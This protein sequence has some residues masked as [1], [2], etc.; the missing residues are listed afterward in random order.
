[1][2]RGTGWTSLMWAGLIIMVAALGAGAFY[3]F[4]VPGLSSARTEAPAAEVT[5]ATWLLHHSVP[6]EMKSAVNPL[7]ADPADVTAGRDLYRE[8]CE[9]CHGYDGSGKKCRSRWSP[10]H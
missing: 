9:L 7:G 8:K 4:I 6:G 1:M 3:L 2:P 5:I 10:Y